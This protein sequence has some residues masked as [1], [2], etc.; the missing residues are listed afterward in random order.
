MKI[1]TPRNDCMSIRLYQRFTLRLAC[2]TRTFRRVTE[3]LSF[4]LSLYS[5]FQQRCILQNEYNTCI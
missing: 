5:L 3:R 4:F 2:T 1:N